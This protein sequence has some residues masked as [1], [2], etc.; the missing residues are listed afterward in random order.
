M[1]ILENKSNYIEIQLNNKIYLI[2]YTTS[3]ATYDTIKKTFKIAKKF[4]SM[5]TSKHINTFIKKYS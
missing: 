4:Y 5:T 1:K 2:S 3:V